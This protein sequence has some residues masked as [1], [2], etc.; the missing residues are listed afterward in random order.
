M[1]AQSGRS[2]APGPNW[3]SESIVLT[4]V[5]PNRPEKNA[6]EQNTKTVEFMVRPDEAAEQRRS[7]PSKKSADEQ[8]F[9]LRDPDVVEHR[10][11]NLPN[12]SRK[13]DEPRNIR[14]D[15]RSNPEPWRWNQDGDRG[16]LQC[17][18]ARDPTHCFCQT[19]TRVNSGFKEGALL[20]W[21]KLISTTRTLGR[22]LLY[23]ILV[24]IG[25]MAVT[26]QQTQRWLQQWSK[27]L[28]W[29]ESLHEEGKET[30]K[31]ACDWSDQTE[32]PDKRTRVSPKVENEMVLQLRHEQPMGSYD[33]RPVSD[34][35]RPLPLL[36][37]EIKI[38]N[39]YEFRSRTN[40]ASSTDSFHEARLS[41]SIS[42]AKLDFGLELPPALTPRTPLTPSSA[43]TE[44]PDLFTLPS[45]LPEPAV[46]MTNPA[47]RAAFPGPT[48]YGLPGLFEGDNITEF[49]E[50][51]GEACRDLNVAEDEDKV[52][53][54]G[55]WCEPDTRRIVLRFK[56]EDRATWNAF[57][58]K[59]KRHWR[60]QDP[61]QYQDSKELDRQLDVMCDQTADTIYEHLD[62]VE[63][64]LT[65]IP[66]KDYSATQSYAVRKI[67]ERF[68]GELQAG[69]RVYLGHTEDPKEK[70]FDSFRLWIQNSLRE[71]VMSG[72]RYLKKNRKE[73]TLAAKR[74]NVPVILTPANRS[75]APVQDTQTG[76]GIDELAGM[77]REMKI[78][79]QKA[80]EDIEDAIRKLKNHGVIATDQDAE[81]FRTF[82]NKSQRHHDHGHDHHSTRQ[83]KVGFAP[84]NG[85]SSAT[86]KQGT[87]HTQ[88]RQQLCCYYCGEPGHTIVECPYCISDMY[89]GLVHRE[90]VTQW[91][92]GRSAIARS[93]DQI[94]R[95]RS[96]DVATGTNNGTLGEVV[97]AYAS[98]FPTLDSW[99][100]YQDWCQEYEKKT[101]TKYEPNLSL[102]GDHRFLQLPQP[103]HDSFIRTNL[104]RVSILDGTQ[105]SSIYQYTEAQQ[106][107]FY[108]DRADGG[109]TYLQRI[110]PKEPRQDSPSGQIKELTPEELLRKEGE[111][112][113]SV[114][115]DEKEEA[116]TNA[117][118]M[119]A[120]KRA[121]AEEPL[122]EED[123]GMTGTEEGNKRVEESRTW[124]PTQ[125]PQILRRPANPE[126]DLPGKQEQP[127]SGQAEEE[128]QPTPKSSSEEIIDIIRKTL[129]AKAS[130]TIEDLVRVSPEYKTALLGYITQLGSRRE[131]VEYYGSAISGKEELAKPEPRKSILRTNL[132]R[133]QEPSSSDQEETV[134]VPAVFGI[135]NDGQWGV[136]KDSLWEKLA[137]G[138]LN[139]ASLGQ[140]SDWM[141]TPVSQLTLSQRTA[142]GAVTRFHALPTL[143]CQIDTSSRDKELALLDSGSECNCISLKMVQKYGLPLR[144]TKVISKGLYESKAFAGETQAKIVLGAQS[145]LCHFF[146]MSEEA[147]GHG[148]LL[149]MPFFKDTNLTFDFSG[150][151]LV[152]ANIMMEDVIVKAFVVSSASVRRT[153]N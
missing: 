2:F 21:A 64:L 60:N 98:Q 76:T 104:N 109:S 55:R 102:V 3:T 27:A 15:E 1:G 122:Q 82:Y 24:V 150:G 95:I 26:H 32:D 145:V 57:S 81:A 29:M 47:Y 23:M 132:S 130:I 149:G 147:G 138:L 133:V 120:S 106:L 134:T 48:K 46:V 11:L 71:G 151:Q 34:N 63:G 83:R 66:S 152:A 28:R 103:P 108:M 78:Q 74:K 123:K 127:P 38:K 141:R 53:R 17:Q 148:I 39:P 41:S 18:G 101:G 146:V 89:H 84:N 143:Y 43:Q 14:E 54:F 114:T 20:F 35:K 121:R 129:S 31:Q 125:T 137:F 142:L 111:G 153:P 68:P 126:S 75:A 118:E 73:T 92:L 9:F 25:L 116:E 80:Q 6:D 124:V 61:E 69:F 5:H 30:V 119:R 86:Y 90:K 115:V 105:E 79:Q 37:P 22:S 97:R 33:Q 131:M 110:L 100:P 113:G 50:A 70:D 51:Y 88:E 16:G 107:N 136:A 44:I 117:M 99:G 135:T 19:A 7:G 42:E 85:Q 58:D 140:E 65:R 144:Q 4:T 59:L 96:M 49:L 72:S 13:R 94:V 8:D 45:P 139:T 56:E 67:W 52:Q 77:F 87:Q 93:P 10:P 40:S 91:V 128:I 62:R 12:Q 112:E 36:N